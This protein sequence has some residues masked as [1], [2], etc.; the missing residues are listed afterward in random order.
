METKKTIVDFENVIDTIWSERTKFQKRLDEN[1]GHTKI[2]DMKPGIV[3][4]EKDF[5]IS[6]NAEKIWMIRKL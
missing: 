2:I 6:M 3:E 1:E 5:T 4:L